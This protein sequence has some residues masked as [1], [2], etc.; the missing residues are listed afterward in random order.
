MP[1]SSDTTGRV[2]DH[3]RKEAFSFDAL[4]DEDHAVQ[5]FLRP[6]LFNRREL[7]LAVAREFDAPAVLDVGGGSG[8]IGE[9]ILDAGASR[10]VDI[11]L[12]DTMLDLARERLDRFG[13]KVELIQGD[14]LTAD[15]GASFDLAL[16]L[17][18]FDYIEDAGAHIRRIGEL[19]SG[20]A[21]ASFPR[22]TW[23]KGP[24][25]KLRYEVINN[26]PIYDYTG[27]GISALFKNAGF[28]R[29]ELHPGKS[30]FL[31]VARK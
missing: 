24:I 2:R 21:V 11:D 22:W 23:T 13:D 27:D 31:A 4:Y 10:Y 20:A 8:R 15:L 17:G 12:S 26:C 1:T 25:R 16:A 18:Y 28:T 3:F 6:G 7:A 30:G 19:C 14:F 5:R 29:V 9:P